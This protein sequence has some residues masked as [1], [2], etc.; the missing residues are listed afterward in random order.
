LP[1]EGC[2]V[3]S[4]GPV[5]IHLLVACPDFGR[6]DGSVFKPLPGFPS[7]SKSGISQRSTSAW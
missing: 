7:P 6:L 3:L 4:L 1:G 5:G 2:N